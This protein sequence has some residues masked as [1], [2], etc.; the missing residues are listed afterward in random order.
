MKDKPGMTMLRCREVTVLVTALFAL[1]AM[2]GAS[3]A[4]ARKNHIAVVLVPEAEVVRAGST[5][6]LAIRMRPDRDWHGYWKNPGDAGIETQA[7]WMLPRGTTAGPLIYPVPTTL[8]V[9]GLMNYV[10]EG[11]HALLVD[12]KVPT[13]LADGTSL[14]VRVKLDWLACTREICV[15]ERG[16]FA[17]G[18]RV[19]TEAADGARAADFARWRA[20]LPR[21]LAEP[22]RFAIEGATLRIGVPL[23]AT[24]AV[25]N[26]YFFPLVHGRVD[27]AAPQVATRDGDR[28]VIETKR[29]EGAAPFDRLEG[30]L[31]IGTGQGLSFAATPGSVTR[32]TASG[33]PIVTVLIAIGAAVLG[34]L[35]LNIMP[36]VFPILSLKALGL[37][38]SGADEQA[39]RRE[40]LAYT[41]GAVATC[42]AL[43]GSLLALRAG[44]MAAGWAFQL[45]NPWVIAV[46][47][48]LVSAIAL[49][50]AGLFELPAFGGGD[51]LARQSGAGGA[52]WT[53]ALAAIVATPCTG[54]FMGAAL[55]AALVLPTVA[56]M[57]VFVGLGFGLALPFLAIGFVPALRRRLPKP[58]P[59]MDRFR[60]I[61][62]V[63][64]FLTALALAWVL[65]RLVGVDAMALGIGAVTVLGLALWWTGRRQAG[66]ARLSWLPVAGACVLILVGAGFAL[67]PAG[68]ALAT[69][70]FSEARLAAL[71]A[72]RKPVF[73][74]FTADWCVTCKVNEKAAIER[75]EVID[76]FAK[77]GTQVLVGDWTR[78]D[79][80]ISKFLAS[81]GR[82][83]VPLYLYYAPGV[84]SPKVLP[85]VLTP[86]ILTALSG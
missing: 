36:C 27:Y 67:R 26:P 41:A 47:L 39:A 82:S 83:G 14:P 25:E 75:R 35:I 63:P 66:G 29:A 54:P 70:P 34:G 73:V 50:L 59:W 69:Q 24:M 60:K 15:P 11:E 85:Q 78:G 51:R 49:N 33:G 40:A 79:A 77:S 53:G 18:I 8:I 80:A 61:M 44:G 3:P 52:F 84:A 55:G 81:Q 22:V 71:T 6:T 20:A 9:G 31:R 56:A 37:A 32:P 64:M 86:G 5:V 19:S 12:L 43:G 38:R 57:G 7:A 62:A 72:E 65:G 4:L 45:Q 68:P 28:L 58:G 42:A 1:L 30:V 13:G 76:A 74:Y 10:Y 16:E 48:L 23:P 46:L 17:T 21:P 2:L